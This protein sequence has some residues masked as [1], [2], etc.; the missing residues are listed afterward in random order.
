MILA[1]LV[2]RDVSGNLNDY[3][4]IAASDFRGNSVGEVSVSG[5]YDPGAYIPPIK[6]YFSYAGYYCCN[7]CAYSTSNGC[8][9]NEILSCNTILGPPVDYIKLQNETRLPL[10]TIR[11]FFYYSI[12]KDLGVQQ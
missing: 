1:E 10:M 2:E 3:I 6:D 12:L 5:E 8:S 11:N 9:S 7:A 4:N